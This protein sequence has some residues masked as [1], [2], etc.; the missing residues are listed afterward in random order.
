MTVGHG[1]LLVAAARL[2]GDIRG[3]TASIP[4]AGAVIDI[5]HGMQAVHRSRSEHHAIQRV[6]KR[7]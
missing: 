1:I 3:P 7:R 4:I 5:L 2:D 6:Q